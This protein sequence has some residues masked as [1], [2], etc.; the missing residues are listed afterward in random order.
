MFISS[1]GELR[2]WDPRFMKPVQGLATLPEINACV[3]HQ[4]A[5]LLAWYVSLI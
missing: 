3:L 4:S 5:N 2:K 1:K